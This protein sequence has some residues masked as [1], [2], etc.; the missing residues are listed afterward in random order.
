MAVKVRSY[1]TL[2]F[3]FNFCKKSHPQDK[4]INDCVLEITADPRYGD[5]F[6]IFSDITR[7]YTNGDEIET[8]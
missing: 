4:S 3:R 5:I 6:K 7:S 2:L 8:G 1:Y